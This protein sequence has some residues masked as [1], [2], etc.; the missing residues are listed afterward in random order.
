MHEHC[1]KCRQCSHVQHMP[2]FAFV[3][4]TDL[5]VVQAVTANYIER[6]MGVAQF[7][8]LPWTCPTFTNLWS[9]EMYEYRVE[10]HQCPHLQHMPRV[11]FVKAVDLEAARAVTTDYIE[12]SMGIV[13]FTITS[14]DKVVRAANGRVLASGE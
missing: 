7:T 9:S 6:S 8:Q 14:I 5:E 10:W 2:R 1:V 11:S 13:R 4:A 12:R 3:K